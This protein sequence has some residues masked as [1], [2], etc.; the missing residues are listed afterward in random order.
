MRLLP[1]VVHL[2]PVGAPGSCN[3]L[4]LER[5]T[6]ASGTQRLCR[7]PPQHS[8]LLNSFAEAI[9]PARLRLPSPRRNWPTCS[10]VT[11]RP[12]KPKP[13]GLNACVITWPDPTDLGGHYRS[14]IQGISFP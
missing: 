14:Q 6:S 11:G 8:Q 13:T 7:Q 3:V 12:F 1:H 10:H 9:S 4:H 5:R 2:A